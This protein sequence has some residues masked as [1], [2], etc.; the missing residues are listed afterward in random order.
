MPPTLTSDHGFALTTAGVRH[1]TIGAMG[2][3]LIGVDLAGKTVCVE[4]AIAWN[5]KVFNPVL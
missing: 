2:G 5:R 4:F 3:S 1:A